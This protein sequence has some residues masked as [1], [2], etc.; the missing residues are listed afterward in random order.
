MAITTMTCDEWAL[1]LNKHPQDS[2]EYNKIM[3]ASPGAAAAELNV[4]RQMIHKLSKSGKLEQ[5]KIID[6]KGRTTAFLITNYSIEQY[7]KNRRP[8]EQVKKAQM[9][10]KLEH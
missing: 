6:N 5:I 3:G 7:A 4:S 1:L 9:K 8:T 10:L 2:D